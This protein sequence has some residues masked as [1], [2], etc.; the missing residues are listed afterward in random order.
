MAPSFS[1][2]HQQLRNGGPAPKNSAWRMPSL[3]PSSTWGLQDQ[4]SNKPVLVVDAGWKPRMCA[5]QSPCRRIAL[6]VIAE[7]NSTA[8]R[9]WEPAVLM[10]CCDARQTV[11]WFCAPKSSR[12]WPPRVPMCEVW[13]E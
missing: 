10:C 4:R 3:Q 9:T 13:T 5:R 6:R 11:C 1:P 12:L 2:I 7:N 8:W